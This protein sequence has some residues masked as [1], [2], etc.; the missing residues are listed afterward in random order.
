MSLEFSIWRIIPIK[1]KKVFAEDLIKLYYF[2]HNQSELWN[3]IPLNSRGLFD[4]GEFSQLFKMVVQTVYEKCT[5]QDFNSFISQIYSKCIKSSEYVSKIQITLAKPNEKLSKELKSYLDNM[6]GDQTQV[7][8][9]YKASLLGG[10]TIDL[11]STRVDA[12]YVNML[13][14]FVGE[15][16]ASFKV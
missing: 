5:W 16:N 10:F 7:V 13:S 9:K 6:F 11:S 12:S 14:K 1:D 4:S 2:M 8:T 15:L 3:Q